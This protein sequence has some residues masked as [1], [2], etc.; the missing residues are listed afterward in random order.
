[1]TL[2]LLQL[3]SLGILSNPSNRRKR[4]TKKELRRILPIVKGTKSP[5]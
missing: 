3:H 2:K 5:E 1:M 4:L